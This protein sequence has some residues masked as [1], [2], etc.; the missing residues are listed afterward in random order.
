[1]EITLKQPGL[2]V[3]LCIRLKQYYNTIQNFISLKSHKVNT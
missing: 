1:M 3:M 2:Y